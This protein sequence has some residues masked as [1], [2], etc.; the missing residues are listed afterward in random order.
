MDENGLDHKLMTAYQRKAF[1]ELVESGRANTMAEHTRI[2]VE[3]LEA[4]R[5]VPIPN[6]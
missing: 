4:G 1:K 6:I 5:A 3:A 2:A